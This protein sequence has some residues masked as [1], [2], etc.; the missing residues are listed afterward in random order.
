MFPEITLCPDYNGVTHDW[1]TLCNSY[2]ICDVNS[3]FD[4]HVFPLPL[5]SPDLE[6]SA[7]YQNITYNLEDLISK[8]TVSTSN[9]NAINNKT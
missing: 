9:K 1:N 8:F 7:F 4:E 2:N 3:F 5:E 6:L